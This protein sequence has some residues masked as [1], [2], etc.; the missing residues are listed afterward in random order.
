MFGK[1]EWAILVIAAFFGFAFFVTDLTLDYLVFVKRSL[2]NTHVMQLP[3]H[4]VVLRTTGLALFVLFGAV[5]S[6]LLSM[7]RRSDT[8]TRR[9]LSLLGSTLESTVDGILVV[10]LD[11]RI[12]LYNKR[13]VEMWRMPLEFLEPHQDAQALAWAMKQIV[14]P[15]GFL[16]KVEELYSRPEEESFDVIE[17]KDGRIFERLSR[18]QWMDGVPIGRVW[19]FR[20]VTSRVQTEEALRQATELLEK[21]V[22]ERTA[23]LS[24]S[25]ELLRQEIIERERIEEEL[26]Q[27]ELELRRVSSR[28]LSVQERERQRISLE[29]HD[30]LGQSLSLLKL[31]LGGV[32]KLANGDDTTRKA[33]EDILRFVDE[34]IESLRRISHDLSP[35]VLEDLGLLAALR[36]LTREFSRHSGIHVFMEMEDTEHLIGPD[37]QIAI[38]RIFQEAFT[39]IEKHSEARNA[40]VSLK[41]EFDIA[42]FRIEDDGKGFD[43]KRIEANHRAGRSLGL[44]AME[45]RARMLGGSLEVS[46]RET[47]GTRI[48]LMVPISK[49][50]DHDVSHHAGR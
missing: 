33:L 18:P 29:L 5:S 7:T 6:R 17:I 28:L 43:T 49:E 30:A 23:E 11:R 46:A 34:I 36:S 14:N 16:Q 39:N 12:T 26:R 22:E 47:C 45:E 31:R 35:Q 42:I 32:G 10:G 2:P 4:E 21:R 1:R 9:A 24:N 8:E 37:S 38:Y 40:W 15:E 50:L 19:S 13:F 41:R 20:D 44:A 27:S 3:L 25:N 48:T